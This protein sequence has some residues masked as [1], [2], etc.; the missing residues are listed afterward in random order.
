MRLEEYKIEMKIYYREKE[1]FQKLFNFLNISNVIIF[2]L[3]LLNYF[4][5]KPVGFGIFL[6][7]ILLSLTLYA[8]RKIQKYN[9]LIDMLNLYYSDFINRN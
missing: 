5:D 4:T 2:L 6:I 3:T 8:Y 7:I 9:Y 1:Q